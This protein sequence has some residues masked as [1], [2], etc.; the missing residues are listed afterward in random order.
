M[1]KR[2]VSELLSCLDILPHNVFVIAATSRP[3][4]LESAIRR[5]GRFDNEVLLTVPDEK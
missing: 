1:E 5:G 3:E 4:T 2:V